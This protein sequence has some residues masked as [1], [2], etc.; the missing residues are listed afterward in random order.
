[1][2]GQAPAKVV[3]QE[4]LQDPPLIPVPPQER[5]PLPLPPLALET[6]MDMKG[7]ETDISNIWAGD[8]GY[9]I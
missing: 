2:A 4:N 1:M 3:P 6:Q 8:D 9:D 5:D 7:Y